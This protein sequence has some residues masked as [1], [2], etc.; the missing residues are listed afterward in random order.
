[1]PKTLPT[2][3]QHVELEK[4]WG[5]VLRIWW[6]VIWRL[7]LMQLFFMA[8]VIYSIE[9]PLAAYP[10]LREYINA[11]SLLAVFPL[12]IWA[13]RAVMNKNFGNFRLS[14]VSLEPATI[15]EA[16]SKQADDAAA[17]QEKTD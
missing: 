11:L 9:M 17:Q 1:M 14:L 2:P 10:L 3:I 6:A 5:R 8:L 16:E 13:L 15:D 7:V 4:R 12:G